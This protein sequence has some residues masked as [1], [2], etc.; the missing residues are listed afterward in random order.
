MKS[1]PLEKQ[2][3]K[4]CTTELKNQ[5][6]LRFDRDVLRLRRRIAR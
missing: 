6:L 3:Y 2:V 1:K 5:A 4:Q